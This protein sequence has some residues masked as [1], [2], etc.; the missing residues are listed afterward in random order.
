MEKGD[1]SG[2]SF[3]PQEDAYCGCGVPQLYAHLRPDLVH[4]LRR[5]RQSN[6]M[7]CASSAWIVIVI[8]I[9]SSRMGSGPVRGAGTALIFR[10]RIDGNQNP[11]ALPGYRRRRR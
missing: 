3:K 1:S 9:L 7:P 2:V 11:T 8:A 6:I 4:E 5:N 10:W